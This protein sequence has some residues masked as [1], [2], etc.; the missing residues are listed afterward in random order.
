MIFLIYDGVPH[1]P[2]GCVYPRLLR[3]PTRRSSH[4]HILI[5][6]PLVLIAGALLSLSIP[7]LDSLG[8]TYT[9]RVLSCAPTATTMSPP[10][11]L[12]RTGSSPPPTYMIGPRKPSKPLVTVDQ[13]QDHLNL[14]DAF[15][16]L[17]VTVEQGKDNRIPTYAVRMDKE[18]RW[19]WFIHLAIDRSVHSS[20]LSSTHG[21]I[22]FEKWVE[23]LQ[24]ARAGQFLAKYH[25]PLDVCMVWHAYMLCPR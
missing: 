22:R 18:S 8:S 20:Y 7:R 16:R 24:Y 4:D 2:A 5:L 15:H 19:R 10:P 21:P 13:V 23:A 3:L 25:P 14:L 12:L 1:L 9:S 11:P 17:R 6:H